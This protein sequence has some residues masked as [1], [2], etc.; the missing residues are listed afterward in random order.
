MNEGIVRVIAENPQVDISVSA[1]DLKTGGSFSYGDSKPFV[2][3]S[4]TKLLTALCALNESEKGNLSLTE[5]LGDYPISWHLKQLVNQSNNDSWA[6][7]NSRVGVEKLINYSDSI[8]ASSFDYYSNS[9]SA[10]DVAKLLSELYSGK[11]LNSSDTKLLLSYMQNTNNEDLIP[12]GVPQG[13]TVYHK[14]GDIDY[15]LHDATI[16]EAKNPF[17]LVVFTSSP[18]SM[19][20]DQRENIIH[21]ITS[22]VCDYENSD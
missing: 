4:V 17:V 1:I 6:L 8:G 2:G 7:L 11:L 9:V 15:S 12:G 21:R 10:T 13:V 19:D 20:Y 3:A 5:S 14:Y 22:L 18:S 16:V